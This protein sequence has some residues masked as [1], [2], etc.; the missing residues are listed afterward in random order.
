MMRIYNHKCIYVQI[1]VRDG[2]SIRETYC[3]L[4]F[5]EDIFY[6]DFNTSYTSKPLA[7]NDQRKRKYL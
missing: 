4:Y 1:Q 6:T 5:I 3:I 2:M 7:N